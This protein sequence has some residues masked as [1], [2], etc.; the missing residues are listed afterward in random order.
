VPENRTNKL[1]EPA[2]YFLCDQVPLA[3][4]A[5]FTLISTTNV[6]VR[7]KSLLLRAGMGSRDLVKQRGPESA[8]SAE[9]PSISS[10]TD[11]RES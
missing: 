9:V 8:F 5:K 11:G 3:E 7:Q 2:H 4:K 10:V 1:K 6:S